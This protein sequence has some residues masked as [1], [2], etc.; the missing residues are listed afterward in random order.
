MS[1]LALGRLR[2]AQGSVQP[3]RGERGELQ[4]G[5]PAVVLPPQVAELAIDQLD[6]V[7]RFTVRPTGDTS[8]TT[9]ATTE[10]GRAFRICLTPDSAT[11]GPAGAAS[12]ADVSAPTA[13]GRPVVLPQVFPGP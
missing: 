4:R 3:G 9:V 10:P 5:V 12:A 6:L 7:A 8:T 11:L 2:Q 1:G 13:P